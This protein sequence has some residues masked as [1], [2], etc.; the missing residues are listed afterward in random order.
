MA[1]TVKAAIQP[2][3][4]TPIRDKH[5][6]PRGHYAIAGYTFGSPIFLLQEVNSGDFFLIRWEGDGALN[7][8]FGVDGD[9]PEADKEQE[10][11]SVH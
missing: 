7:H 10:S 1:V 4:T 8:E 11:L 9:I 5:S 6:L 3:R 2:V